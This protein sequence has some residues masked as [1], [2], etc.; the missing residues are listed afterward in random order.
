VVIATHADRPARARSR[1]AFRSI[2]GRAGAG[3]A[4]VAVAAMTGVLEACVT[5]SAQVRGERVG[6]CPPAVHPAVH[7]LTAAAA[8]RDQINF[9]A[10]VWCIRRGEGVR[11]CTAA[12][13]TCCGSGRVLRFE[14]RPPG[15]PPRWRAGGYRFCWPDLLSFW[16]RAPATRRTR[17]CCVKSSGVSLAGSTCPSV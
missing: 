15:S 5:S 12:S 8:T 16:D 14:A 6:A 7:P 3:S 2:A 13:V 17:H 11:F 10:G 1:N 9:L 4:L